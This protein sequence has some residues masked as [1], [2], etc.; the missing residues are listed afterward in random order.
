MLGPTTQHWMRTSRACREEELRVCSTLRKKKKGTYL[1]L[2]QK[3]AKPQ[4][5]TKLIFVKPQL[6]PCHQR[7]PRHVRRLWAALIF[8]PRTARLTRR[9]RWISSLRGRK[10]DFQRDRW[11]V[12][13]QYEIRSTEY[14]YSVHW[15]VLVVFLGR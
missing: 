3:T 13:S 6:K 2:S 14:S 9:W 10:R 11:S 1:V 7:A 8:S 12:L 15:L 5:Q 4:S